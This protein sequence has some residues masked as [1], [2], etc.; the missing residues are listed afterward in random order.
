MLAV[1][2]AVRPVTNTAHLPASRV[3]RGVAAVC[4]LTVWLLGL[5]ATSSQLHISLHADADDTGHTCAITLFSQGLEDSLGCADLVVT[6]ALF[7]AGEIAAL[8]V[9]PLIDTPDRL[10]PGRGP[11]L[12]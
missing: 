8:T 1:L 4:S 7:R 12:C 11:P 3:L 2:I 9:A 6:P 10:P 5:F